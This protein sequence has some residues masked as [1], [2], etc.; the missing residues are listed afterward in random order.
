MR[1]IEKQWRK[2]GKMYSLVHYKDGYYLTL[3]GRKCSYLG[4][5]FSEAQDLFISIVEKL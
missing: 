5:N 3:S 2:N 4:K 1:R